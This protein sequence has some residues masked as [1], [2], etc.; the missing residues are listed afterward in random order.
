MEIHHAVITAA[1]PKQRNLPLQSLVDRCGETKTA[2]AILVEE[3]L[4][5][6]VKELAVVVHPGDTEAFAQ[7]AGPYAER[8]QYL[9]QRAPLG[10]GD[11][12]LTARAFTSGQPFLLLVGDHLCVTTNTL[13]CARQLV[14]M[15][16]T[17]RCAVSAVQATHESRLLHYG[18]VGGRRL[19]GADGIY[20][21]TEVLEKPSPTEAEQRLLVPGLRTGHYLCHFGMHVLTPG[22]MAL[23]AEESVRSDPLLLTPALAALARRERCLAFEVRGRRFDIGRRYGLLHAQLALALEG[24]DRGEILALLV[25]LLASKEHDRPF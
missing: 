24:P 18:A 20:E 13:R 22:V 5:A 25:D 17:Q 10:F 14:E 23:L 1:G 16:T 4:A 19:A 21:I 15:A 8:L 11:A 2:L 9:E 3:A 12:V 7:A 6:G